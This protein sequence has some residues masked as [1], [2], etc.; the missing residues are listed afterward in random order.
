MCP[1]TL[2]MYQKHTNNLKKLYSY[3]LTIGEIG[4]ERRQSQRTI[5]VP[6]I[7]IITSCV[8]FSSAVIRCFPYWLLNYLTQ[9]PHVSLSSDFQLC[10]VFTA[11]PDLDWRDWRV[12]ATMRAGQARWQRPLL[13]WEFSGAPATSTIT[14]T[15]S[16]QWRV[17]ARPCQPTPTTFLIWKT[18][19]WNSTAG[20]TT[21][22]SA[23][24]REANVNIYFH[25]LL[26]VTENCQLRA[27]P[28]LGQLL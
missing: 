26:N 9:I 18:F 7:K 15:I 1:I 16:S 11:G 8:V 24:G 20:Q 13:Q 25:Y 2:E 28:R 27:K 21:P 3:I 10:L 12:M 4:E 5:G 22:E 6:G 14:S 19:Q 23:W 17:G